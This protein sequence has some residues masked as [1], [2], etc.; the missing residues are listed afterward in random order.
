MKIVTPWSLDSD[1]TGDFRV[2]AML[3]TLGRLYLA[4]SRSSMDGP[5]GPATDRNTILAELEEQEQAIRDCFDPGRS[6]KTRLLKKYCTPQKN[7]KLL[8]LRRTRVISVLFALHMEGSCSEDIARV[9][10][11]TLKHPETCIDFLEARRVVACMVVNEYLDADTSVSDITPRVRLNP[12]VLASLLGSD[13]CIPSL[14][15]DIVNGIRDRRKKLYG[16]V[17][18]R[19][20]PEPQ[21]LYG[22][23]IVKYINAL[24]RFSPQQLADAIGEKV[25]FQ[26]S[27]IQRLS[28]ALYRHI[29]RLRRIYVD[30]SDPDTLMPKQNLCLFGN[31]GI[32][33]SMLLQTAFSTPMLSILP[34][35]CIDAT[36]FSEA[37]YVGKDVISIP[38][39][40]LAE[41]SNKRISKDIAEAAGVVVIEEL[42]K[43]S[44]T[45]RHDMV[46]RDGVMQGLLKLIEGMRTDVS[47]DLSLPFYRNKKIVF[48]SANVLFL[49]TGVFP[50]L[51]VSPGN[52]RSHIGFAIEDARMDVKKEPSLHD[53]ER[54]GFMGELFAR[55][56]F[57]HLDDLSKPELRH[58]LQDRVLAQYRSELTHEGIAL[59]IEDS[60]VDLVVDKAIALGTHGRSVMTALSGIMDRALF[61]AFSISGRRT[62]HLYAKEN[63]I[64]WSIETTARKQKTG[65]P[66]TTSKKTEVAMEESAVV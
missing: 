7:S 60:V 14:S 25:F 54:I 45:N 11:S 15:P 21:K 52:R 40:L 23:D 51:S 62:I 22:N 63:E 5:F 38:T 44:S 57:V 65:S 39:L 28:L 19:K 61:D 42:D 35:V 3:L 18:K 8:C 36:Q 20:Q 12:K 53:A 4:N 33:K 47:A 17:G 32:G 9:A 37:G 2:P 1:H 24:P 31:T 49:A 41:A 30:S 26:E 55:F 10:K 43:L 34:T 50:G 27:A 29:E 56:G 16:G 59:K 66:K 48:D 13:Y 58:L 46:S 6:T 64:A